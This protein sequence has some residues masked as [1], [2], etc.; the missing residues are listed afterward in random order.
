MGKVSLSPQILR[1][2]TLYCHF[3]LGSSVFIF[4]SLELN[5]MVGLCRRGS[6]ESERLESE[7]RALSWLY[8]TGA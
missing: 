5:S 8:H 2:A 6:L 7:A 4:L 3:P 1:V